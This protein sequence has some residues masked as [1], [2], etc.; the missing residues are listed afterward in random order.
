M[1]FFHRNRDRET[2]RTPDPPSPEIEATVQDVTETAE[3][4]LDAAKK[5]E[6]EVIR[7]HARLLKIQKENALGPRFWQAVSERHS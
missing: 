6:P 7:R 3:L 1:G 5:R 4:Q 2:Y